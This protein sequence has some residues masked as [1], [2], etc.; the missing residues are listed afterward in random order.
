M[1]LRPV[2]HRFLDDQYVQQTIP[3]GISC[4]FVDTP[5]IECRGDRLIKAVSVLPEQIDEGE[6]FYLVGD[7]TLVLEL[8]RG[9]RELGIRDDHISMEI[10]F[11]KPEKSS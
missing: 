1:W 9:L 6:H 11:N 8:S 7:G 4:E 2:S 3:A 5:E 10:F